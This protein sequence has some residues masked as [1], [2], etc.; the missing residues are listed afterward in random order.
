MVPLGRL[1]LAREDRDPAVL[2]G[3]S[4][5]VTQKPAQQRLMPNHCLHRF[6]SSNAGFSA[7]YRE[8]ETLARRA[9]RTGI[10]FVTLWAI[11]SLL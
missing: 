3:G 7:G 10:Y 8:E 1:G 2:F 5:F 9:P 6:Y 11:N 4:E